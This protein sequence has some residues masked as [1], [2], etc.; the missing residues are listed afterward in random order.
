MRG[1]CKCGETHGTRKLPNKTYACPSCLAKNQRDY[2]A[3][4]MYRLTQRANKI[5]KQS[6][7]YRKESGL[8]AK[9]ESK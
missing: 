2:M 4:H 1:T 8:P 7:R 5:L 9:P 6:N 3:Q